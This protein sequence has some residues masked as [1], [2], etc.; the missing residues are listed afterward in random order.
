MYVSERIEAQEA[1]RKRETDKVLTC[2][3]SRVSERGSEK[4]L[5]ATPSSSLPLSQRKRERERERERERKRE[6]EK[7]GGSV[8]G[9]EGGSEG[10]RG[11]REEKAKENRGRG[12]DASNNDHGANLY[13]LL[14][15]GRENRSLFL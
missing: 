5:A 11:Q 4:R 15:F 8:G 3:R 12:S 7:E 6:R 14:S 10:G 1:V 9:S 2:S 13:L